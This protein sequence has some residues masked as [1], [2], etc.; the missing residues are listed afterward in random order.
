[1]CQTPSSALIIRDVRVFDGERTY[2]HRN[3]LVESGA[4]RRIGGTRLRVSKAEIVDGK[5]RTLL[6]GLFD[7][8][9]RVP[10]R[11][12][13]ALHEAASL[14]ITTVI[15]M[16]GGGEKLKA[17][18]RI[19]AEDPPNMADLRA[20]GF[21]ATGPGSML[22]TMMA[23]A[24]PPIITGPEQAQSW[25]DA[26]IAEGSDFIKVVYDEREGGPLTEET[27]QEIVRAAHLRGRLVV[28]H[29]LA[30]RK[31]QEAIAAGADGLAHLYLGDSAEIWVI[32]PRFGGIRPSWALGD[33][34]RNIMY[35]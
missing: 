10:V 15:D 20:A 4:I 13:S 12:E 14:G 27:L 29:V 22:G 2:E 35:S 7:A 18:K 17:E 5:G 6:P 25:V 11:P 34:L 24:P 28:V 21:G 31:T 32:R 8:H 16:F 23:K 1:M 33:W 26:R 30:Q 9:V 3:V 19:E